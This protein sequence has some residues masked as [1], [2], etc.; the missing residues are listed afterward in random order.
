MRASLV[1]VFYYLFPTLFVT[2]YS[3]ATGIYHTIH[4]YCILLILLA[5]HAPFLVGPS[6]N[7]SCLLI[8]YL[9]TLPAYT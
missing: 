4:S 6:H 5:L 2:Y 3:F 7:C 8:Y 1:T 9:L